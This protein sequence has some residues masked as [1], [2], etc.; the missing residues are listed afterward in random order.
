MQIKPL[1]IQIS[2]W[3]QDAGQPITPSKVITLANLLIDGNSTQADLK[4]F[5]SSIKF[6]E[7]EE[8]VDLMYNLV[9]E[10]MVRS[11]VAKQLEP[12]K[13]YYVNDKGEIVSKEESVG[14]QVKIDVIHPEYILFG[15]EVGTEISQK[16]YGNVGGQKF[17]KEKGTRSNFKSSHRDGRLTVIG[18]TAA[19]GDAVMVIIIYTAEE[20]N[21]EQ[22]MG[23]D[24]HISL[25]DDLT[26]AKN[27][28]PGKTF[29]GRLCCNFRG[30]RIP[31]L[32]T[33]NSKG[34][35]MSSI[36]VASFRRLDDPGVYSCSPI[37]HPFA[38]F[39][40]HDSRLQVP[41]LR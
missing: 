25:D 35:I 11:G 7:Q 26:I 1:L 27:S 28:G 32:I 22:R 9:Y 14:L 6:F 41:F 30:K 13:H 10:K 2:L 3:K 38:L 37:L 20:I 29:P 39:D 17:V 40:A 34:Y 8:N 12:H 21:F 19:N 15:D 31:A 4:R 33:S 36:L 16:N 5:Q 23:H 18:L 24:I